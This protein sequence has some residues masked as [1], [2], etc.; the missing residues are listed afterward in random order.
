MVARSKIEYGMEDKV[1][2]FKFQVFGFRKMA[3]A[4]KNYTDK[5]IKDQ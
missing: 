4:L 3:G 2:L 1:E 5:T